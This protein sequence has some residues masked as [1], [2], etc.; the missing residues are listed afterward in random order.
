[1]DFGKILK[2]T[3]YPILQRLPTYENR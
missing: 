2:I 3:N 1:L